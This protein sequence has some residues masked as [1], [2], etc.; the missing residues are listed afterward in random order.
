MEDWELIAVILGKGSK[1]QPVDSLSREL[2]YKLSGLGGLAKTNPEFLRQFNGLGKAKIAS[3]LAINEITCRIRMQLVS[4][5]ESAYPDILPEIAEIL[6]QKTAR[7]TR[8]CFFLITFSSSKALL[9]IHLVAR[10]SLNEVGIYKRDIVKMMLDDGACYC[11]I[12][13]NHPNASCK[14]SNEDLHL[15]RHLKEYVASLEIELIDQW[16]F[17]IDGIHSCRDDKN[18]NFNA[19]WTKRKNQNHFRTG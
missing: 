13:H 19:N 7:E 2:V 5:T 12:S 15:F 8:E 9:H 18:I 3:L 6:K 10:G 16:I 14:P 17:G 1:S 11:I 4:D